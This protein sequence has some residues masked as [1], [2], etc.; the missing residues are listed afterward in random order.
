MAALLRMQA[1]HSISGSTVTVAQTLARGSSLPLPVL[2]SSTDGSLAFIHQRFPASA[3]VMG[4]PTQLRLALVLSGGGRLQQRCARGPMLDALWSVGQFNVVLPGQTGTYVSPAVE[5]AGL[6]VGVPSFDDEA[7]DL[8]A[9]SPL[10][11]AL[12]RDATVSALLHAL[13]SAAEADLL[14]DALLRSGALAVVRRLVQLAQRQQR[15]PSA[16]RPLTTDQLHAL[17]RYVDSSRDT[18]PS[19]PAMA[20]VLG[21]EETRF[22]RAMH[23]ATGMSPHAF[24]VDR[25]MQWA[26][27]ELKRGRSVMDVAQ[28]AGY[29]N[30]SK[31]A[32]AFRRV[33]GEAPSAQR[34]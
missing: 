3:G 29:A 34:R 24:L 23:A 19:V 13:R 7:L 12:H 9:L 1:D 14:S 8:D 17:M 27:L 4:H 28:S 20:G 2:A 11:G 30:A 31:F 6:A 5:V 26:Q 32:A 22:R 33:I 21:M 15:L 16:A 10:A 18:R 25:L